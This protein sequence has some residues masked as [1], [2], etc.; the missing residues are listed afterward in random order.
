M[1]DSLLIQN[2]S[3]YYNIKDTTKHDIL[4]AKGKIICTAPAGEIVRTG[5]S[6]D[7]KGYIAI[8]GMIDLHIHG[9][10]GSDSLDGEKES[11][12]TISRT[13]ASLG[14]TGFLSAMVIKPGEKNIHLQIAG[15]CAG[16]DMGG[17]SLL[18]IYVEGPFINIEKRGGIVAESITKP[19]SEILDRIIEESAGK[20][21]IMCVAPELPGNEKIIHRLKDLDII[22]AFGHSD[23][24]YEETKKGFESGISHVTHLFNAMRPLHH[25]DPGPLAAIFEHTDISI[26]LIAD[27]HHIHPAMVNLAS[28]LATKRNIACITDGISG[29]GLPDGKYTYNNSEYTSIN[30]LARYLDGTLIGSTMGLGKIA[31]NYIKFTG[32]SFREAIDCVTINPARILGIDKYKGSIEVGKDADIVIIDENFNVKHSIVAGKTVYKN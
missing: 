3:L 1:T 29:M 20:L 17:A 5:E 21:K 9:A 11:F 14:T 26:E 8:P 31:A 19:S 28:R 7:A 32:A 10:G 23:A 18:G 22:A 4:V 25:R 6:I 24:G 27:S 13:L 15:E 2:V 30:G 16:M 12:K